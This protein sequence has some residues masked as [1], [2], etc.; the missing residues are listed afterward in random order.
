M[1]RTLG[2]PN[3]TEGDDCPAQDKEIGHAADD[4][5]ALCPR[6]RDE[7]LLGGQPARAFVLAAALP[8]RPMRQ[9]RDRAIALSIACLNALRAKAIAGIPL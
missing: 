9:D 2:A 5:H 7:R 6:V 3:H 1:R 4:P 8:D